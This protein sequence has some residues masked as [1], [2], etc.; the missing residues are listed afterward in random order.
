MPRRDASVSERIHSML[1][2]LAVLAATTE[3]A[4]RAI[5]SAAMQRLNDS[6]KRQAAGHGADGETAEIPI[7]KTVIESARLTLEE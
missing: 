4:E 5:L 2:E 3:V 1:G 7:L 6:Q